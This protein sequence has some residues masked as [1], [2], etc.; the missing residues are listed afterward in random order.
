MKRLTETGKIGKLLQKYRKDRGVSG[1][2]VSHLLKC[3]QSKI[4]KIE[5]GKLKPTKTFVDKYCQVIGLS[6]SETKR[7]VAYTELFMLDFD[8]WRLNKYGTLQ[9]NQKKF[10][11]VEQCVEKHMSFQSLFIPGL[12]QSEEYAKAI[13]CSFSKFTEREV[14]FGV[15]ERMKRQNILADSSK[16][17]CFVIY[18]GAFYTYVCPKNDMRNQIRIMLSLINRSNIDIRILPISS[19]LIPCPVS[20]Y[21]IYDDVLVTVETR[22]RVVRLWE[23]FEVEDYIDNFNALMNASKKLRESQRILRRI[24]AYWT[25]I[26]E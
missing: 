5:S 20:S 14:L 18:E 19:R 17:F 21:D 3:T 23:D 15:R 10:G 1:D 9:S 12:L 2:Y 8:R 7:M 11:T 26:K 24:D 6:E 13:F 16:Y 4:S 22:Q 25:T